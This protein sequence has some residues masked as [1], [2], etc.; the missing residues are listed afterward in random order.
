MFKSAIL[1]FSISI[2]GLLFSALAA[3]KAEVP[4]EHSTAWNPAAA[5]KYMD[6]RETWWQSWPSAQRDHKTVCISCHSALPY[7][8]ARPSLRKD[9]KES[10][11]STPEQFLMAGVTKRV[12]LWNE[13]EPFYTD[14]KNGAPKSAEARGTESVLNA[15]ILSTEDARQGHLTDTTRA[16]F[17]ALWAQ[18][19]P[20][21]EKAGAWTWL[22]F[23]L[24][25]WEVSESQ[26]YGAAMAAL[27]VGT[28]PDHY[29][30]SPEI[31]NN[32]ELL[33]GFLQRGYDQQ[34]LLNKVALLWA[35]SKWPDLL[36]DDQRSG[37]AD[38]I[39]TKQ[40]EDGGWSLPKLGDWKRSDKTTYPV[41]SDGYSTGLIVL[42]LEESKLSVNSPQFKKGLAWLQQN[43]DKAEG[44]W[45]AFSLNKQRDPV[46]DRGRFMTDAATAF[47]VLALEES[48]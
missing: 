7:A 2:S 17:N 40:Q 18:Q 5:A 30:A 8:L 43:Q 22:N 48:R 1:F 41:T 9:L 16:A 19:L 28:A 39:F 44:F 31:K 32:L 42:A 15:L 21:G 4:V 11:P 27:A 45:P 37:L 36:T 23:H 20:A 47:S 25:P 35:S 24:A 34:P 33:K 38:S 12:S 14:D 29:A 6:A 3:D 46:S 26:Y 10:G 13:V